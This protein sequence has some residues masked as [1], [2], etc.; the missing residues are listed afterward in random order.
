MATT[1]VYS[2]DG[3]DGYT[4]Y[5]G[6]EVP[7]D[8]DSVF[9][10][11]LLKLSMKITSRYFNYA[12]T[13]DGEFS[14]RIRRK[15]QAYD[16]DIANYE[17]AILCAALLVNRNIINVA[18][19]PI[20][21]KKIY[22]LFNSAELDSDEFNN[23]FKLQLELWAKKTFNDPNIGILSAINPMTNR[24]I[25]VGGKPY[26]KIFGKI[27]LRKVTY[28]KLEN[29]NTLDYDIDSYCV[30]S[31]L[32][33]KLGKK[34]YQ[35]I[36][37][38][39][40]ETP[41]PT[42]IQLTKI[43][44]SIQYDLNVYMHD[45]ECIQQQQSTNTKKIDI[46]I[47]SNHMHVLKNVRNGKVTEI[48]CKTKYVEI[49]EFYKLRSECHNSNYK[50]VNGI[51][52][53]PIDRYKEIEK[54]FYFRSPFSLENINFF[55]SCGIRPVRYLTH[56]VK[57]CGGLD[58][59]RCYYDILQNNKYVFPK[60]DGS[61]TTEIYDGHIEKR[62]F[63]Y[64]EYLQDR[65]EI[66]RCIFGDKQFWILGYLI[67]DMGILNRCTIK[68]QHISK[69]YEKVN[70]TDKFTHLDLVR[71]SGYLA[72][73]ESQTTSTYECNDL[74]QKA[75]LIK[76]PNSHTIQG[77]IKMKKERKGKKQTG[78]KNEKT[79][80]NYKTEIER[81]EIL[82]TIKVENIKY[83]HKPSIEIINSKYKKNS[84]MYVYLAILQYAR[85]Q[86]WY[87]YNAVKK[88]YPD[89]KI[90]KIYTDSIAFNIDTKLLGKIEMKD[91]KEYVNMD[92][93]NKNFSKLGF[94]VK[95]EYSSFSWN[96]K[97]HYPIEPK[98][99]SELIINSYDDLNE[100]LKLNK[101]FSIN[102]KAGY[103]KSHSIKNQII[104]Y[105]KTHNKRYMICTTTTET[106][107][108]YENC[109]T[110]Q[111]VLFSEGVSRESTDNK[112]R[113]IDYLIIDESSFLTMDILTSIEHIKIGNPNLKVIFSG[114][115]NQCTFGRSLM[116]DDVYHNLCDNN[117]YV[118]KWHKNARYNKVYD[119]FLSKLLE[120]NHGS[121]KKCQE[122]IKSFFK[123]KDIKT[124]I[125]TNNIKLCWTHNFGETLNTYS[126]VHA[127]QGKTY[128]EYSIYQINHMSISVLYTALS[129]GRDPSKIDIY[130]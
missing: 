35:K 11:N 55:N 7:Y 3:G 28:D 41:T 10:R 128:D 16:I 104:R 93:F 17:T 6:D 31:Y 63:Y 13:R 85:L 94:S 107:A 26:I 112:F 9:S 23:M 115:V 1:N 33:S 68:Y 89:V 27:G 118:M 64:I 69:N 83:E 34:E 39:L 19:L 129:R 4:N 60:H 95:Y 51:K 18:S 8:N 46:M 76:Y 88:I 5:D 90:K 20:Q 117:E 47:H 36:E 91:N 42:Y 56:N 61:E 44:N 70:K 48:E 72:S 80:Y 97:F 79:T 54:H 101:G 25:R 110:I 77:K 106:T 100:L 82:K 102:S 49:E 125:D 66:E 12:K 130:L 126:T 71:Y 53:K 108:Q 96:H 124:D 24:K 22:D 74:E 114:D 84:G 65:T 58:L 116:N 120:F 75:Y 127:S 98:I 113:D 57:N 37:S 32:K 14:Y 67:I 81:D 73:F 62:G 109:Y 2:P 30:P 78:E 111:N 119:E 45:K 87:I 38:M 59:N 103:G 92:K 105:L 15:R 52:Y 123:I 40:I 121:E 50:I 43:L 86:I 29:Y 21:Y 99:K 122:H